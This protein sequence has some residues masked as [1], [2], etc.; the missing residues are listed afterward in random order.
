MTALE[1]AQAKATRLKREAARAVEA[2]ET[3]AAVEAEKLEDAKRKEKEAR[4]EIIFDRFLSRV[5]AA[6]AAQSKTPYEITGTGNYFS[7]RQGPGV[8][9]SVRLVA[10]CSTYSYARP[11]N[12]KWR[13]RVG[14]YGN[15]KQWPQRK[16]GSHNYEAIAEFII[17]DL[18]RQH[19]FNVAH[20]RKYDNQKIAENIAANYNLEDSG[21]VSIAATAFEKEP[22]RVSVRFYVD[23]DKPGAEALLKKLDHAG[24]TFG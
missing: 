1:K 23:C 16:D 6:I 13:A 22:F 24:V 11:E 9:C 21:R 7:V 3:A 15:A 10:E 4:N 2:A 19:G 8:S 17:D 18:I 12:G 14:G 20:D 5:K